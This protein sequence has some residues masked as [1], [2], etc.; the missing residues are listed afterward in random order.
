MRRLRNAER[1]STSTPKTRKASRKTAIA[2]RSHGRS[3]SPTLAGFMFALLHGVGEGVLLWDRFPTCPEPADRLETCPTRGQP[4]DLGFQRGLAHGSCGPQRYARIKSLS[5]R[6][7]RFM[8][9]PFV[10][11]LKPPRRAGPPRP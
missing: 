7:I 4:P 5:I 3:G 8:R 10:F 1:R 6:L 9:V 11:P 2:P